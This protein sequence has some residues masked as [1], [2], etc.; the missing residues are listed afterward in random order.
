MATEIG[1]LF[2][3]LKSFSIGYF[4]EH[5][6]RFYRGGDGLRIGYATHLTLSA[7]VY[8]YIAGTL[9]D[10]ASG[11]E[12]R[13][14]DNPATWADAWLTGG[15]AGFY[16]DILFTMIDDKKIPDVGL[17]ESLA[18]PGLGLVFDTFDLGKELVDGDLTGAAVEAQRI[19]KTTVPGANIFY[20][21]LVLDHMIWWPMADYIR[22]GFAERVEK[23]AKEERGH[24]Y[25]P[26]LGPVAAT[27]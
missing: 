6:S 26:G 5:L 27:R 25:L 12:P 10:I 11:R 17:L 20:S 16:G 8:G 19:A 24:E 15:G 18:G 2:L 23:R 1:R 3:H 9:K 4:Q 22:P 13:P 7:L 21:K 14:L